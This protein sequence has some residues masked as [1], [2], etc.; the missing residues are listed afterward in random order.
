MSL[1]NSA[2]DYARVQIHGILTCKSDLHIGDG[3]LGIFEE[4]KDNKERSEGCTGSYNTVYLD[5]EER[6]IY[7]VARYAAHYLHSSM[8]IMQP[9]RNYLAMNDRSQ[10]P[11]MVSGSQVKYASLTHI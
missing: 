10:I 3:D 7:L 9:F 1:S 8:K 5:H 6:A 11:G 4:R 2:Y